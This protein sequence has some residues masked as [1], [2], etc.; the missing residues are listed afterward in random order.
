M[1]WKGGRAH[2][3][4]KAL[5]LGVCLGFGGAGCARRPAESSY[6]VAQ[7]H[8]MNAEDIFRH[9]NVDQAIAEM[10]KA[11]RL[12]R[13]TALL[14][15]FERGNYYLTK[16]DYAHAIAD[17]QRC[18]EAQPTNVI[19]YFS[20]GTAYKLQGDRAHALADFQQAIQ[21]Q[22]GYVDAYINLGDVYSEQGDAR[23]AIAT[24]QLALN[25]AP[26]NAILWGNLGWS[27]YL[28][29]D[30]PASIR[31]S[32]KA[33]QLNRGLVYVRYNLGLVYAV[34]KDARNAETQ[35]RYALAGSTPDA[36]Q[37]ATKDVTDALKR[38]PQSAAVLNRMLPL[39][40]NT[41]P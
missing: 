23:R 20:R 27:Q 9:G 34:L 21:L 22:P 26:Q 6:T 15:H 30:Y 18:V 39:I 17:F 10:D 13:K 1:G 40:Q 29:G 3:G 41:R 7:Q 12:D 32:V 38:H 25:F 8:A 2:L 11:I 28:A 24:Y 19:A 4:K 36:Q 31:S 35:Y 5:L 33:L 14:Y 16:K 37:A